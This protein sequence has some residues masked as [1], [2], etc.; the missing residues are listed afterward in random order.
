[1]GAFEV[2]ILAIAP[3]SEL[4]HLERMWIRFLHSDTPAGGY[5]K[6]SGGSL[7][8]QVSDETCKKHSQFHLGRKWTEEHRRNYSKAK[9][10][11]TRVLLH[12]RSDKG[13]KR[14]DETRRLISEAARKTH[15]TPEYHEVASRAQKEAWKQ[16]RKVRN[17][18]GTL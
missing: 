15:N 13:C 2:V 10:G 9:T 12:P 6:E 18:S 17:E 4:D 8:K 3:V 11:G 1:M 16:R 14:S 5:N 7:C